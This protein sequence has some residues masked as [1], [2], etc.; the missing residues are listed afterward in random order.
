MSLAKSSMYLVGFRGNEGRYHIRNIS[1]CSLLTSR[2]ARGKILM[3]TAKHPL[4]KG[5]GPDHAPT[6][7]TCD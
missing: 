7:S 4:S 6:N 5:I 1:P 2:K 3:G